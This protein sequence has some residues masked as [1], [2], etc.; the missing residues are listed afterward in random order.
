MNKHEITCP[1][2]EHEFEIDAD[3]AID[4]VDGN[5]E[6]PKCDCYLSL[7]AEYEI[8]NIYVSSANCEANEKEHDWRAWK[9]WGVH[10]MRSCKRCGK[11]EY[12]EAEVEEGTK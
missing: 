9:N 4:G 7:T 6:C 5:C 2:C 11:N 8:S 10:D 1:W 12:R 3:R